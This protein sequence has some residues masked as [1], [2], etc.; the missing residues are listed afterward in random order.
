MSTNISFIQTFMADGEGHSR[1]TMYYS[2]DSRA[3]RLKNH[4]VEKSYH[5]RDEMIV[6]VV[7]EASKPTT[8]VQT[9]Q[10]KDLCMLKPIVTKLITFL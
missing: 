2:K 8:L 4:F 6:R 1:M 3:Y 10:F 9:L 5:F 7:E